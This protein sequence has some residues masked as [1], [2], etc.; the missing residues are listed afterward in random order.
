MHGEVIW[1]IRL[2]AVASCLGLSIGCAYAQA[3]AEPAPAGSSGPVELTAQQDH[4]RLM[5]LLHMTSI[6]RGA[7]CIDDLLDGPTLV[8]AR[9]DDRD[10]HPFINWIVDLRAA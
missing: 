6:R 10:F 5:D 8:K 9:Y 3:P 4:Q 7:D 1:S 2:A